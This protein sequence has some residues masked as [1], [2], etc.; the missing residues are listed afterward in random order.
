MIRVLL[1]P[2]GILL[3]NMVIALYWSCVFPM[4]DS[5]IRTIKG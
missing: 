4:T 5:L 2:E 1:L 3:E